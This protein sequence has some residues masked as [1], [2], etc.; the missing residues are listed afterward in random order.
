MSRKNNSLNLENTCVVT[1]EWQEIFPSHA[2]MNMYLQACC[3]FYA[4][5]S[6][7]RNNFQQ[8]FTSWAEQYKSWIHQCT[9]L[10]SIINDSNNQ[11]RTNIS[12]QSAQTIIALDYMTVFQFS[13]DFNFPSLDFLKWRMLPISFFRYI[14]PALIV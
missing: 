6:I 14:S 3:S 12:N 1:V 9:Y 8:L 2:C 13:S 10:I 7:L 4:R 5:L 11:K